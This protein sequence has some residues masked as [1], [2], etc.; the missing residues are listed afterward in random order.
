MSLFSRW[1]FLGVIVQ[2]LGPILARCWFGDGN[3]TTRLHQSDLRRGGGFAALGAS[4]PDSPSRSTCTCY[5]TPAV[6]RWPTQDT[7]RGQFRTGSATALSST[8]P[9][10][11]N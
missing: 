11:R 6:M 9:A 8:P 10:T 1:Y 4:A 5:G 2:V 3:E 7:T